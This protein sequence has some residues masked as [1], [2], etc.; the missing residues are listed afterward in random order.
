MTA[1]DLSSVLHS[2]VGIVASGDGGSQIEAEFL[3]CI[4]KTLL[5]IYTAAPTNWM[6][7]VPRAEL[8]RAP[9]TLPITVTNQSKAITFAGFDASWMLDCT[10]I[11]QGDATQNMLVR[12]G[13]ATTTLMKPY[14]G[15]TGT[16][17]AI[18][19]QDSVNIPADTFQIGSPVTL[20]RAWELTPRATARD[21][22]LAQP[23]NVVGIGPFAG[24]GLGFGGNGYGGVGFAGSTLRTTD[25][26]I[27]TPFAFMVQRT[28]SYNT[29]QNLR[30]VLSALPDRL[31]TLY[32]PAQ[33]IP[34]AANLTDTSSPAFLP[35]RNDEAI[36]VPWLKWNFA[37]NPNVTM[38]KG[39]LKPG[40]DAAT[41]MLKRFNPQGFV[42]QSVSIGRW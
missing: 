27:S 17:T 30:V 2:F 7:E 18:I 20:D 31:Y 23:G 34:F 5:E 19:Y 39:D 15:T 28:R 10:I 36:L 32:Y 9:I 11:I 29:A 3:Q 13:S 38:S 1:A 4:N 14:L 41:A 21:L 25:K 8:V 12:D 6:S 42:D 40:F 35:G 22:Q 37:D 33:V 26:Q 16:T 24:T